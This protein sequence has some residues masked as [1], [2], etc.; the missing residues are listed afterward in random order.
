MY[1][2]T[3]T[4]TQPTSNL[5]PAAALEIGKKFGGAIG[6]WKNTR[7][8][9]ANT[10]REHIGILM[11][12]HDATQDALQAKYNS[13][14]GPHP[15]LPDDKYKREE[16]E[17]SPEQQ[18][19]LLINFKDG[20]DMI[21]EWTELD[22]LNEQTKMLGYQ[23]YNNMLGDWGQRIEG[24][25]GMSE[26]MR[27]S[28]ATPQEI[29]NAL[30]NAITKDIAELNKLGE[31]GVRL[32]EHYDDGLQGTRTD[33]GYDL[34]PENLNAQYALVRSMYEKIT[35]KAGRDSAER[36]R[37]NTTRQSRDQE[38]TKLRD[39]YH[40]I[41]DTGVMDGNGNEN[42][43]MFL[44]KAFGAYD[45][46]ADE[47][48][49]RE[50]NERRASILN[51]IRGVLDNYRGRAGEVE[52][53]SRGRSGVD[54]AAR[55]REIQLRAK[56]QRET[57]DHITANDA[58]LAD[59]NHAHKLV[60]E[61]KRAGD[62]MTEDMLQRAWEFSE[63]A[64][65]EA[66]AAVFRITNTI[67]P[68]EKLTQQQVAEINEI[69]SQGI[70][71]EAAGEAADASTE[72]LKEV[73]KGG[74]G[75]SQRNLIDDI[76]AAER[77]TN[78]Q[79]RKRAIDKAHDTYR[80]SSDYERT[81]QSYLEGLKV[82]GMNVGI[83]ELR[84]IEEHHANGDFLYVISKGGDLLRQKANARET[85]KIVMDNKT[86][87]KETLDL[88]DKSREKPNSL[89]AIF[90]AVGG[91][92]GALGKGGDAE[93]KFNKTHD[94][95]K[96]AYSRYSRPLGRG[97]GGRSDWNTFWRLLDRLVGRGGSAAD[98]LGLN[99]LKLVTPEAE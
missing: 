9:K 95:M 22:R 54:Y 97:G 71:R 5:D 99:P 33:G 11:D 6:R 96:A 87:M 57:D 2:R 93:K 55:E 56:T 44:K 58:R 26:S 10:A 29:E 38:F 66:R 64:G 74:S 35:G 7:E 46:L 23:Q 83:E 39:A 67:R 25:I 31:I 45:A 63:D 24:L 72:T 84:N 75:Y 4:L 78:G 82:E 3:P 12:E 68:G 80:I 53:A 48:S 73:A 92:S 34:S 85:A 51:G 86:T 88:F 20:K 37:M 16:F 70:D 41:R 47:P 27:E 49:S 76:A 13:K 94:E 79:E 30:T 91:K 40:E 98:P 60:L 69:V 1:T 81:A 28:G 43:I 61:S 15:N 21:A 59:R 77:I 19:F 90:A 65:P 52:R 18:R 36:A 62:R 89:A 50:M 14:H 32:A 42:Q 8:G 17:L